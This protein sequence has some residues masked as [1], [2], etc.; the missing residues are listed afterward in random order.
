M[1]GGLNGSFGGGNFHCTGANQLDLTLKSERNCNW[2]NFLS[3]GPLVYNYRV[4]SMTLHFGQ[5]DGGP[6]ALEGS[7]HTLNGQSF[8]GEVRFIS[9]SSLATVTRNFSSEFQLIQHV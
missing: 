5:R 6:G 8:V 4:H 9:I 7:E 3:R 2:F 1:G